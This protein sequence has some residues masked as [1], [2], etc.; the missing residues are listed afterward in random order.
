MSYRAIGPTVCFY[1]PPLSSISL[2]RLHANWGLRGSSETPGCSS[3]GPTGLRSHP[4][5]GGP[6]E[7]WQTDHDPPAP[8][9]DSCP[10]GPALLQHQT[11]RP[12]AYAQTVPRTSG[13]QSVTWAQAAVSLTLTLTPSTGLRMTGA[14]KGVV[15]HYVFVN[16]LL[17]SEGFQSALARKYV[18]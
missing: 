7:S 6:P 5:P 2:C 8:P 3:R 4:P 11:G 12:R 18:L 13:G 14:G 17:D 10:C 9:S 1:L 16:V 15:W